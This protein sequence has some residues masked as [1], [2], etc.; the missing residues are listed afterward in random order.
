MLALTLQAPATAAGQAGL[1]DVQRA[2][3]NVARTP[4]VVGAIGEVYADGKRVGTA[5]SRPRP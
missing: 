3:A 4:V 1:G 5:G 2:V